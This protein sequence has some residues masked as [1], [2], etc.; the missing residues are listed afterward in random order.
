MA[1]I[2]DPNTAGN[3][4]KV[5]A[6]NSADG[7]D[8]AHV[9]IKP[10]ATTIGHYRVTH[11][12]QM[13]ATQAATSRLFEIQM[14]TAGR[15]LIPTRCTVRIIS[16]SAHTTIIEDAI[17]LYKATGFSVVDTV[18]TVTPVG[19]SK[20]TTG[21]AASTAN[22]RGVTI[23]GAAAGMTGATITALANP[24]G[25]LPIVF[26]QAAMAAADTA[27]RYPL[28]GDMLDDVNGTHPFVLEQNEGLVLANKSL[29]GAAAGSFVYVDF[30]WC[31]ALAY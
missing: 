12:F 14:P 18:N 5:G 7:A 3:I 25:S 27:P 4:T 17:D 28:L 30:S 9:Q 21:F 26:A 1:V 20:R 8:G 2:N 23:A 10:I 16:I 15:L 13:V 19:I 11:R 6:T 31:E 22:I 29:L 24:V